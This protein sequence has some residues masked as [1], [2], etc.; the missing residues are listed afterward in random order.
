MATQ[1]MHLFGQQTTL[2]PQGLILYGVGHPAEQRGREG[3]CGQGQ[4][5]FQL[6]TGQVAGEVMCQVISYDRL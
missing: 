4:I 6:L 5:S 1:V 2:P 3:H